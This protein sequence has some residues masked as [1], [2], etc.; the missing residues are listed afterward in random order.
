MKNSEHKKIAVISGGTG[1]LGRVVAK[2]LSKQGMIIAILSRDKSKEEAQS[3][4]KSLSGS[5]HKIYNCDLSDESMVQKTIDSIEKEMGKIFVC[6]HT[7][8][9]K[10]LR[11]TLLNTTS[12]ELEEALQTHVIGGFN[13]LSICA[14]KLR[15]S[16]EGV[17]VGVTTAGVVIPEAVRSLGGYIPA[18]YA[19]QGILIM[20][21]EE[22]KDS[23]VRVYSVA[24]GFMEGGMNSDIPKAFI[25]M[26]RMK[27]K[28]L[29]T[30]EDVAEKIAYLCSDDS[31]GEDN[32]TH[33]VAAEYKDK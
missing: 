27:N 7:A 24:P 13:F 6:I 29:T 15:D 32:F 23:K 16:K 26:I 10:P 1:Y 12:K 3:I 19:L 5:S 8:G 28:K 4:L 9:I 18:K 30:P 31:K 25:E 21:R 11:K 20:L 17:I 2:E 33:V 14:K 22:L